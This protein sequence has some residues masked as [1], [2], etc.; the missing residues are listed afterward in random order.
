MKK[1][2]VTVVLLLSLFNYSGADTVDKL[3]D[4]EIIIGN[5]KAEGVIYNTSAGKDFLK[6]L[7]VTLKME[8]FNGTEKI[9]YLKNKLDI[10]NMP[11]SYDPAKGDIAYF[12]P[13]GNMCVF[14]KDFRLSQNLY[15]I[16]RITNGIEYFSNKKSD[17][18]ITIKIK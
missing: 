2:I 5:E 9:S 12:A 15:S 10:S 3:A 17:F 4:I 8:D 13:W 16:G 6:T 11:S 18:E 14:Y 7:P 1:I